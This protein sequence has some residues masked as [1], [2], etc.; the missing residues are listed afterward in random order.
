MQERKANAEKGKS[1]DDMMAYIDENG[2]ISSTPPDPK[3]MKTFSVEE[4]EIGIPRH[5]AADDEPNE[6]VVSFFNG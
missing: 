5:D 6:G 4:I 1:L 2:N 3:K